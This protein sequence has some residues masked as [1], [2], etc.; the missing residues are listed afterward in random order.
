LHEK[1]HPFEEQATRSES[2]TD[3]SGSASAAKMETSSALVKG[4]TQVSVKILLKNF[5][6]SIR[7]KF[8]YMFEI[9]A[10]KKD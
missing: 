7:I 10:L 2:R 3:I 1:V 4:Q 9:N 5:N 8:T 6:S